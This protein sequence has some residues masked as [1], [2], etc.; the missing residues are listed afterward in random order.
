[1]RVTDESCHQIDTPA[2]G[3]DTPLLRPLADTCERQSAG[4]AN[5]GKSERS[6]DVEQETETPL[7][8][9]ESVQE[10]ETDDGPTVGRSSSGGSIAG[11]IA[12]SHVT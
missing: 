7:D 4:T 11:S 8:D 10:D 6:F 12:G 5:G 3:Y 9:L 1:M 2:M